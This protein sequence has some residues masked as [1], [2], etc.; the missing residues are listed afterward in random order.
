MWPNQGKK[1][2]KPTPSSLQS[3]PFSLAGS[4]RQYDA[5]ILGP[6][7]PAGMAGTPVTS[8]AGRPTDRRHLLDLVAYVR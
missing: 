7:D 3:L 4:P 5:A 6:F 8:A 2:M 1:A